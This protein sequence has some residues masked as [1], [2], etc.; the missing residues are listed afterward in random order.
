MEGTEETGLEGGDMSGDLSGLQSPL[1]ELLRPPSGCRLQGQRAWGKRQ[2]DEHRIPCP[3]QEKHLY[4]YH[5][6]SW[7]GLTNILK[8]LLFSLTFLAS[9]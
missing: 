8:V 3:R 4:Y 1:S 6:V 9:S 5:V 7:G 2:D